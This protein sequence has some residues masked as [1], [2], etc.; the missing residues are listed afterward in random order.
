MSN[1][2]DNSVNQAV[3]STACAVADTVAEI[4][5]CRRQKRSL[6]RTWKVKVEAP[7]LQVA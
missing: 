7:F 5:S 1:E 6:S 2:H 3:P 4:S